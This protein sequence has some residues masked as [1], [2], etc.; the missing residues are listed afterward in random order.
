MEGGPSGND[1]S[2][3]LRSPL[4]VRPEKFVPVDH[5]GA[6]ITTGCRPTPRKR[7]YDA[8]TRRHVNGRQILDALEA[9]NRS[10]KQRSQRNCAHF[11]SPCSSDAAI[12]V[13]S[14][15]PSSSASIFSFNF[16]PFNLV[17]C[18]TNTSRSLFVG[19]LISM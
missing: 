9:R 6:T 15:T 5:F 4:G 13:R 3:R 14:I 7:S 8:G 1:L 11:A 2:R 16:S 18:R 19:R 10:A 17:L 12:G